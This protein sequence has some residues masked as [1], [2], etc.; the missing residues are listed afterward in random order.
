MA[1]K[2]CVSS[3]A[4]LCI[5]IS[6]AMAASPDMYIAWADWNADQNAC[7][8]RASEKMRDTGFTTR[9]EVVNNR[10]IYGMRGDYTAGIR[11]AADKR[12]VF[13][14]VAG[15]EVTQASRYNDSLKE[16]F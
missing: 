6:A 7:V 14:V 4:F 2:V 3:A 1:K 13:F 9:F 15:P 5:G 11:C 10:T 12:I 16:G 8:Q